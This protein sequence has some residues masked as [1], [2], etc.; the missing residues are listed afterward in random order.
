MSEGTRG[1]LIGASDG[2]EIGVHHVEYPLEALVAPATDAGF[3]L[4]RFPLVPIA[5]WKVHDIRF[6]FDS[7]FVTPDITR[8][9]EALQDLLEQHQV[10]DPLT[11]SP[12]NPPQYPPLS[13]FGHADPVGPAEDPDV[14][15]KA[16]SG[17]RATVIYALLIFNSD[18][19]GAVA[20]W[21]EIAGTEK[22]GADQNGIMRSRVPDGTSNSDLIASYMR[23]L[24]PPGLKVKSQ[25]FLSDGHDSKGKY[26]GC[27]SFNP[28]LIFSQQDETTFEKAAQ[29]EDAQAITERNA[30]N[31][32]N[33]RVLIFLFRNGS[34]VEPA[35]WPCPRATEGPAGCVKR[36]WSDGDSR[37][38]KRDPN[39][40]RKFERTHDTFA[41]RFY[42]R[43]ADQSPCEATAKHA[44][45]RLYDGFQLFIPFAP[46]EVSMGGEEPFKGTAD[47]QG[48]AI[49]PFV[50]SSLDCEMSWGFQPEQEAEAVLIFNQTI[51][52]VASDDTQSIE[53]AHKKLSNLGYRHEE[54]EKNIVAFQFDYGHL[55]D[56]YV[57]PS[58]EL[59]DGTMNLL[60]E[61][62]GRAA[63]DLRRPTS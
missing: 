22:W 2:G 4:I 63:N 27:G 7:S 41:C 15:N 21:R 52:L 32:P 47:S 13:V 38:H 56:P 45:V 50:E 54:N 26:Q 12:R 49:F 35:K 16:L 14:Y 58:G 46:F 60:E 43:I 36:F 5:C 39:Q 3:N 19:D 40:N 10:K 9:L 53:T 61:V 59:D 62:Y 31:A 33:R 11:G 51:F 55:R 30:A 37:R 8:E 17:R 6:T 42:Q 34:R 57:T 28:V 44:C 20:L 24:C 25:D 29:N 1:R 23:G 48:L 18:P